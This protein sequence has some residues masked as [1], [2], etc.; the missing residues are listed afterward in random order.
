MEIARTLDEYTSLGIEWVTNVAKDI[1][2][3]GL[4]PVCYINHLTAAESDPEVGEEIGR[5]L[6]EGAELAG[7]QSGRHPSHISCQ[8]RGSPGPTHGRLWVEFRIWQ[9]RIYLRVDSRRAADPLTL[10]SYCIA[11]YGEAGQGTPTD[12]ESAPS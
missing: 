12:H 8:P 4:T 10:C 2:A 9:W 11:Q 5:G 1:L 6:A 7:I 3:K